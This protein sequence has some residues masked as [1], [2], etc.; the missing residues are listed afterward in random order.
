MSEQFGW[1]IGLSAAILALGTILLS[2]RE[3]I[4]LRQTIEFMIRSGE[5]L[6][7]R[8]Q[9]CLR[10]EAPDAQEER[11]VGVVLE[12][13]HGDRRREFRDGNYARQF[14]HRRS[15]GRRSRDFRTAMEI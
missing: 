2:R 15:P 10:G 12:R 1:I 5:A 13:R 7:A 8:Q 11:L 14:R 3:E 4:N 9:K 6:S